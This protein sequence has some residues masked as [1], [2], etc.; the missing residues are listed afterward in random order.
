MKRRNEWLCRSRAIDD[1]TNL[2]AVNE[3]RQRDVFL[4]TEDVDR[5]E[6]VRSTVLE[7]EAQE[8]THIRGTATA[9]LDRER[10]CEVG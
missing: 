10:R 4:V 2:K 6:V 5:L 1:L 3:L 7:L 8:V 9:Q